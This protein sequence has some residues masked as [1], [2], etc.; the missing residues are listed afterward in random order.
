MKKIIRNVKETVEYSPLT[1]IA[2]VA[3]YLGK[4]CHDVKVAIEGSKEGMDAVVAIVNKYNEVLYDRIIPELFKH[5]F[6]LDEKETVVPVE[7]AL[8]KAPKTNKAKGQSASSK[9]EGQGDF[10]GEFQVKP[11]LLAAMTDSAYGKYAKKTFH[12][13]N[14]C[15]DSRPELDFFNSVLKDNE[16]KYLY[17]TGMLTSDKTDFKVNYID[18]ESNTL[19][20]Y[21]PDFLAQKEDGSY[22]IVEVKGDNMLDDAVVQAKA[23]S[24]T[25]MASANAMEY[26]M[27]KE[28]SSV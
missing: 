15:F 8:V 3:R 22:V 26:M 25:E 11:E 16:V 6:A 13:D 12:L 21:Y 23:K 14:Y 28:R 7:I 5:F 4:P 24:A 18:P 20:T 19:R 2:E 27:V 10:V 1:L 9:D 17:F